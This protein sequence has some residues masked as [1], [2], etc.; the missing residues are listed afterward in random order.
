MIIRD[1]IYLAYGLLEKGW[2]G[3]HDTL[4]YIRRRNLKSLTREVEMAL[5]S[6]AFREYLKKKDRNFH[7]LAIASMFACIS[8]WIALLLGVSYHN[9]P[10]GNATKA[11]SHKVFAQP[12]RPKPPLPKENASIQ[13]KYDERIILWHELDSEVN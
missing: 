13:D 1:V 8:L 3:F 11:Y 12:I 10:K 5:K 2:R 6:P 7:R 4:S 9:F